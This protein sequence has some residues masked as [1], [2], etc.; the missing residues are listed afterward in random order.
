MNLEDTIYVSC[1]AFS[2]IHP[3]RASVLNHLFCVNGNGYEW[4]NGAL[5]DSYYKRDRMSVEEAIQDIF[6]ERR[7]YNELSK[8][9]ERKWKLEAKKNPPKPDP[10]STKLVDDLIKSI[11]AYHDRLKTLPQEEQDRIKEERRKESER[12]DKKIKLD[13]YHEYRIPKD[14]AKRVKDITFNHWYPMSENFFKMWNFPKDIQL[15]W[16]NGIIEICMLVIASPNVPDN[17]YNEKIINQ[18]Q[19]MARIVLGR[20]QE[21]KQKRY[22]RGR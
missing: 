13:K 5:R 8:K 21:H 19:E 18:N 10:K 15:N 6:K 9:A 2:S 1:A 4:K 16:L 12:L 20:A 14:I 11:D 22:P 17:Y 3:N 7:K